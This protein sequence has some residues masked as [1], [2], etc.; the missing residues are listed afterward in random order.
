[1]KALLVFVAVLVVVAATT[2]RYNNYHDKT[3]TRTR[4]KTDGKHRPVYCPKSNP[5]VYGSIQGEQRL[6]TTLGA[7]SIIPATMVTSSMDRRGTNA[8]TSTGV[9][10]WKYPVLFACL[11]PRLLRDITITETRLAPGPAPKDRRK[12][13]SRVLP[14]AQPTLCMDPSRRTTPTTRSGASSII[15]NYGL[16]ARWIVVEQMRVRVRRS[17][18]GISCSYLQA[19]GIDNQLRLFF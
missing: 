6:L 11:K 12:A 3:R 10:K 1:M 13:P 17:Q 2:D 4:S 16:R 15:C 5:P 18:V 9:A 19:I 14:E 8:C 7:S